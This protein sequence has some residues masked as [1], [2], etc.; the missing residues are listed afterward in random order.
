MSGPMRICYIVHSQS[1]FAAPYID[2][3][4]RRVAAFDRQ[5]LMDIEQFVNKFSLPDDEEFPYR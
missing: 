1:H 5:G 3:F 4:A 2:H